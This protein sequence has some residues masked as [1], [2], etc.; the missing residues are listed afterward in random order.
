MNSEDFY[1][2]AQRLFL[3]LDQLYSDHPNIEDSQLSDGVLTFTKM[4]FQK[5]IISRQSPVKEIWVATPSG[6]FHFRWDA[7]K[8]S[9][10]DRQDQALDVFIQQ[11]IEQR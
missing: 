9:W 6:G 8:N 11:A 10:R 2:I 5:I 3:T 1:D 7:E 4:N